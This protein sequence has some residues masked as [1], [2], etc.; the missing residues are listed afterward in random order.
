MR[1]LRWI[2]LNWLNYKVRSKV[3]KARATTTASTAVAWLLCIGV[4]G[5][6]ATAYECSSAVHDVVSFFFLLLTSF[7]HGV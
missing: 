1:S 2:M 3:L 5:R 6:C 7:S 4:C